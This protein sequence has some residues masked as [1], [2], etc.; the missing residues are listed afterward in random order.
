M[1]KGFGMTRTELLEHYRK[2]DEKELFYRAYYYSGRTEAAIRELSESLK[3]DEMKQMNVWIPELNMQGY[4]FLA[5][6]MIGAEGSNVS[7]RKHTR[8]NPLFLHQHAFFEL[9]YVLEGHCV[10][11]IAESP[12][13]ME[14]GDLC[15][16][17]PEMQHSLGVFDDETIVLNVLIRKS[18]FR[19]TFFDIFQQ[20]VEL[21]NFFYQNYYTG[22]TSKFIC[23]HTAGNTELETLLDVLFSESIQREDFSSCV[24]ENLLRAIFCVMF[25][26]PPE[27]IA[28][29]RSEAEQI[30][31]A[32]LRYLQA[33]YTHICFEDLAEHFH[34]SESSLRRIL[35]QATGHSFVE[36]VRDIRLQKACMLLRNTEL[37]VGDIAAQVGYESEEYFYRL[38]KKQYGMTPISYRRR[39]ED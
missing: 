26:M 35:R 13:S 28:L 17:A 25:R 39:K 27:R 30:Q 33:H 22:K 2:F 10:N 19:E 37:Q 15:I 36:L 1:E 3:R 21:S 4:G 12:I 8:Y 20:D 6:L 5:E 32:V 14:T 24:M 31:E 29:V 38:F 16:I 34:L 18:T 7:V 9:I 11:T 23:Y